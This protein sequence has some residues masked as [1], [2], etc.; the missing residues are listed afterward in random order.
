MVASQIPKPREEHTNDEN[1]PD[2]AQTEPL[3]HTPEFAEHRIR[4]DCLHQ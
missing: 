1:A 2:E 4:E 3:T